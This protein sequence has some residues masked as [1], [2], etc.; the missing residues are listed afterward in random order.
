MKN[1]TAFVPASVHKK[2]L[3]QKKMYETLLD[4]IEEGVTL[5]N[6]QGRYIYSNPAADRIEGINPQHR[7]GQ[8]LKDVYPFDWESSAQVK[9]MRTQKPV[10]NM[11]QTYSVNNRLIDVISNN[12]PFYTDGAIVGA[13]SIFQDFSTY[14]KLIEK[15]LDLQ[16]K[17]SQQQE[18]KHPLFDRIKNYHFPDIIGKSPALTRAIDRAKKMAQTNSPVL[19]YGETGTGKELFAR[20]IHN[21]GT[22][23]EHPFLAINCAAIPENLLEGLLFGTSRGSFT[24]AMDKAGLFEQANGGTLF[25]DEINA[26]PLVLQGKLLRAIEEKKVRRIGAKKEV[27]INARIISSCNMAPSQMIGGQHLRSDLFY[28]IAVAYLEIPPLRDR[29]RDILILSDHFIRYFNKK[30]NRAVLSLDYETIT[31]F[32]NYEWPGNVRQLRHSI[33]SAMNIIPSDSAF[34]DVSHLPEYMQLSTGLNDAGITGINTMNPEDVSQVVQAAR[35]TNPRALQQQEKEF[36]VNALKKTKGNIAR[37]AHRM[38]I[39]RQ[40]LQYRLKKYDLKNLPAYIRMN[41]DM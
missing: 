16:L 13:V 32:L 6:T 39:T 19:I 20:S 26:M 33:E 28:R 31:G 25:L 24:G 36:I 4:S 23:A 27:P 17:L 18:E 29:S 40:A 21:A 22:C 8:K 34:I 38:R 37:T 11:H 15:N 1:K 7:I 2:A 10:L 5:I 30:F 3:A 41:P 9:A 12:Y 14:K 35:Q